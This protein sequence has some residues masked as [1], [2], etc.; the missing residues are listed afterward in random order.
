MEIS[1]LTTTFTGNITFFEIVTHDGQGNPL[2]NPFL[3]AKIAVNDVN[4]NGLTIE[5]RTKNG[6][7]KAA[8]DGENLT[9]TRVTVAGSI[10]LASISS[11]WMNDEGDLI[12][13]KKPQFRVYVNMIERH[14]RKQSAPAVQA[15]L[16]V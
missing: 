8:Q 2:D 16:A 13:R 10:D 6:L 1:M 5:V 9:G 14:G 7:L 15:E 11:H 12:A 4:D 3:A